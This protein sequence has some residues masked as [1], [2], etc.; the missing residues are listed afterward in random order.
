VDP[1][2]ICLH[3]KKKETTEGKI[4]SPQGRHVGRAKKL[5]MRGVGIAQHIARPE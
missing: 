2:I 3:V 1:E 5:E 4:Y